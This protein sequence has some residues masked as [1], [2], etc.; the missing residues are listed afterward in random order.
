MSTISTVF[1]SLVTIVM[2]VVVV[3]SWR[4]RRHLDRGGRWITVGI[5]VFLAFA[6]IMLGMVILKI[7][8]R[9]IQEVQIV[10]GTS[11]LVVGFANWMSPGRP[12]V[13]VYGLL[14]AFV[15][16]WLAVQLSPERLAAFSTISGPIHS[17]FLTAVAGYTLFNRA[18]DTHDRWT[19][20][21]WFWAC[22]GFMLIFGTESV[23]Y[24]F[25]A[26]VFTTRRDLV[27]AAYA[28]HEAV[29]LGGYLLM[30]RGLLLLSDQAP[31]LASSGTSK[32]FS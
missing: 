30:V 6:L 25:W 27:F 1:S 19:G 23:L 29:S 28:F 7:R 17:T 18:R 31:S 2:V 14:G 11:L 9:G 3:L 4:Q 16:L 5:A 15:A 12:R 22:V 20:H 13:V 32:G 21:F 8:T 26:Q 10:V 24:P